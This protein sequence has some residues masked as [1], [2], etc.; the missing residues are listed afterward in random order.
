[1]FLK[2]SSDSPDSQ[3]LISAEASSSDALHQSQ[4]ASCEGAGRDR[5]L[6]SRAV[7][8]VGLYVEVKILAITILSLKL[9][10]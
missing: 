9:L 7:G 2:S 4:L 3:R 1:M 6:P 8:N 5:L 10:N